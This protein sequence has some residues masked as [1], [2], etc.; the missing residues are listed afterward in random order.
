M[1]FRTLSR[2][3]TSAGV[4]I[5]AGLWIALLWQPHWLSPLGR[6]FLA[7]PI[8][9]ATF[10]VWRHSERDRLTMLCLA[11]LVVLFLIAWFS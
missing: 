3:W 10:T 11:A 6:V 4:V 9:M 2:V 1:T 7:T 8:V 5:L